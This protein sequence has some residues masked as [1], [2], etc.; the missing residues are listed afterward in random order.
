MSTP[1]IARLREHPKKILAL[2]IGFSFLFSTGYVWAPSVGDDTLRTVLSVMVGA[3]ASILAILISVT[4]IS[5]QLVATRYAPRMAT[6]PFRTPL[7]KGTFWLF[8]GSILI[9]ILLLGG[10]GLATTA[11]SIYTGLL[12]TAVG[13][14]AVVLAFLYYFV[15]GMLSRSSPERL[16]S[17]FCETITVE[18]YITD[19]KAH[20]EDETANVHP[21]QRLY[22][23]IM[24]AL[25]HNEFT[26]A[27]TALEQYRAYTSQ[28]MTEVDERDVFGT[29]S[30]EEQKALFGPVLRD[31]L[32]AITI[33]AA[34]KNEFQ[35]ISTAV[36]IQVELGTQGYSITDYSEIPDDARW[37]LRKMI[38]EAP[39]NS[40]DHTTFNQAWPAL[41]KLM[42]TETQ[43]QRYSVLRSGTR[44]IKN[45]LRQS[46]DQSQEPIRHTNAMDDLL[47][48]LKNGHLDAL[49]TVDSNVDA[50]E[51]T[52]RTNID[53][54]QYTEPAKTYIKQAQFSRDAVIALSETLLQYRI[55]HGKWV[56]ADGNFRSSWSELC[57]K[58]ADVGATAYAEDLCQV[59]IEL[60]VVEHA[61]G[62]Y[63]HPVSRAVQ[64]EMNSDTWAWSTHLAA[65]HEETDAPIVEDAFATLMEY[66]YQ[67]ETPAVRPLGIDEA[68][69][70]QYYYSILS[71]RDRRVLNV[72]D[73]YHEI[74]TGL[75]ERALS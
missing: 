75:R 17:L 33:Q 64:R 53:T 61:N 67:E 9:D 68:Q 11:P 73:D 15:L 31:H 48:S 37:G 69:H 51:L 30:R 21:L 46:L 29:A 10:V 25:S 56:I 38:I 36:E 27:Q 66:E 57:V 40:E 65:V 5:T 3:Q 32:P 60:A 28:M 71:L 45:R 8:T 19:C 35:L 70:G 63:D 62:P 18:E 58:A 4:L 34:E 74:L 49:K 13:I 7:F 6:L 54:N 59:L 42:A 16:V 50:F 44:L 22:R 26:T 72:Y 14:F 43:H 23:F 20:A 52:V 41:G 2:A 39:V 24:A 1:W 55:D 12:A 47:K